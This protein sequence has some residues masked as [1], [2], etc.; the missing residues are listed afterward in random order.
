M[1]NVIFSFTEILEKLEQGQV[2][3]YPTEAV[4]G[5]GCNPN[6]ESVVKKLLTLKQRPESKGLILIAHDIHLLRPYIDEKK[7]THK[8]W[9]QLSQITEQA[10][11]WIV[12]AKSNVPRFIRGDFDTIAIRL[13]Q[14]PA[15]V[16]LCQAAHFPLI[17]TSANLSG[18]APCRNAKEVKQQFGADFPVLDEPT[19]GRKNPSEIRDIFSQHIYRQG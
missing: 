10:I 9:Q 2:I 17:S 1:N 8:E 6:S 15:V 3:A 12:P 13:C 18:K 5:L 19:L 7:L 14:V 4:F 11:T 16:K